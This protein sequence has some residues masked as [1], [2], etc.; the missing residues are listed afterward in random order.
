[1]GPL[2][3]LWSSDD[4]KGIGDSIRGFVSKDE[5]EDKERGKEFRWAR[6]GVKMKGEFMPAS[7]NLAMG[8]LVYEL[9]LWWELSPKITIVKP[10]T[11]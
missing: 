11:T 9:A 3:H 10:P 6:I 2:L 4:L 7:V 5:D 1:M 8:S